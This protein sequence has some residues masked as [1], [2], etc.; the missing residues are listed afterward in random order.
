M[1]RSERKIIDGI[2]LI[3]P[4]LEKLQKK[5]EDE[6]ERVIADMISPAKKIVEALYALDARRI[7]LCNIHV[8]YS[9]I[10]QGLGSSFS[11]LLSCAKAGAD[12]A[13]YNKART[14]MER[15][16]FT[17]ERAGREFEYLFK[18]LER[19]RAAVRGAGAPVFARAYYRYK[20]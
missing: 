16:G 17:L 9:F 3:H 6:Q 10:E 2:M 20:P 11:V 1:L 12:S 15:A 5:I 14:C 4:M 19:R 8:L 13:L 18:R 7:D